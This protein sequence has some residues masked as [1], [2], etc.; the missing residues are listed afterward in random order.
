MNK[1]E[2]FKKIIYNYFV[3]LSLKKKMQNINFIILLF[4]LLTVMRSG[5]QL[6]TYYIGSWIHGISNY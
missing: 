2:V 6:P 4:L 1:K 5:I 3:K